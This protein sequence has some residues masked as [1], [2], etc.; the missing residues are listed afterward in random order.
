MK[1]KTNF[2]FEKSAFS[3]FYTQN[4]GKNRGKFVMYQ[5]KNPLLKKNSAEI[6]GFGK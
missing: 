2:F 1:K 6:W 5:Q 3:P 4:Q